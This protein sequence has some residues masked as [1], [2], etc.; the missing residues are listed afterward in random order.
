METLFITDPP[1]YFLGRPMTFIN[2]R[3][4]PTPN[5]PTYVL[6]WHVNSKHMKSKVHGQGQ[7]K[8]VPNRRK[9]ISYDITFY[10]FFPFLVVFTH[11]NPFRSLS[12]TPHSVHDFLLVP[13]VLTSTVCVSPF[14]KV[15]FSCRTCVRQ[16]TF[17]T[18]CKTRPH[19][20]PVSLPPPPH[21]TSG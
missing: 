21:L 20:C 8:R 11:T 14:L 9:S 7:N 5:V 1:P 19:Q 3:T 6:V 15:H 4:R 17:H 16:C 13:S 10:L 12:S 2:C 18:T